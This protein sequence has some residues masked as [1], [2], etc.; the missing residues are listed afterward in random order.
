MNQFVVVGSLETL[1]Y[2]SNE[3]FYQTDKTIWGLGSFPELINR[4]EGGEQERGIPFGIICINKR[5][6]PGY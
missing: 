2:I 3:T 5:N 4:P 1:N 6:N